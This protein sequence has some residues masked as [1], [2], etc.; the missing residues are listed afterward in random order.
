[1]D[2]EKNIIGNILTGNTEDISR[3]SA[4]DFIEYRHVASAIIELY[5]N[6]LLFNGE[7][8]DMREIAKRSGTSLVV[9][10]EFAT[11]AEPLQYQAALQVLFD[12]SK[13]RLLID[14]M[15]EQ[16]DVDQIMDR[17]S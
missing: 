12:H 3:L 16:I 4:E 10:A 5:A 1:M 9:I 15:N 2:I 11:Y 13:K 8:P 14:C 6:N 17:L 7:Q